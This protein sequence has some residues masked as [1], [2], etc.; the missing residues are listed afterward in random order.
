MAPEVATPR[1]VAR[2]AG[3]LTALGG[4]AA[5]ALVLGSPGGLAQTDPAVTALGPITTL[6]GLAVMRWGNRVPRI[7]YQVL[8]AVGVVGIGVFGYVAPTA[9]GAVAGPLDGALTPTRGSVQIESRNAA[10]PGGRTR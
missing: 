2:T 10:V 7:F 1:V 5:V 8:L 3:L 9:T 6:V 4:L